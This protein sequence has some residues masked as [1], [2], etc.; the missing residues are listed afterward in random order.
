MNIDKYLITEGN[1]LSGIEHKWR[2]WLRKNRGSGHIENDVHLQ[3]IGMGTY[4]FTM[5]GEV[6]P[7]WFVKTFL[8]GVPRVKIVNNLVFVETK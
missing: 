5:K 2:T 4:R 3:N 8:K 7:K 1:T 6:D